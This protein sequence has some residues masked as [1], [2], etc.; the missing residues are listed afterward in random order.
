MFKVYYLD[1]GK[2][3]LG[4]RCNRMIEALDY[5]WRVRENNPDIRIKVRS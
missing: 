5:I 1:G 3:V 4:S 2:W